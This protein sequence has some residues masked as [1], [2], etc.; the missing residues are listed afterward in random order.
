[1][2]SKTTCFRKKWQI[3]VKSEC[4]LRKLEILIFKISVQISKSDLIFL[5]RP[6]SH[7][8][9][10]NRNFSTSFEDFTDQKISN[11]KK[12][13]NLAG[14][15]RWK[16]QVSKLVGSLSSGTLNYRFRQNPRKLTD[17]TAPRHSRRDLAPRLVS[18]THMVC[19]KF[20]IF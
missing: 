16:F 12:I 20:F 2:A 1:M 7:R 4:F 17:W 13:T 11:S 10:D 5:I 14:E 15:M 19:Y 6:I 3:S 9:Y 18:T 8:N